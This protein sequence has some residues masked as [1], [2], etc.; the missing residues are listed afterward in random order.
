ML[1]FRQPNITSPQYL[2]AARRKTSSAAKKLL[3][4]HSM[5]I[6]KSRFE[7]A[8]AAMNATTPQIARSAVSKTLTSH[9]QGTPGYRATESWED[10]SK[11]DDN[12]DT[13]G[14][15]QELLKALQ[16]DIWGKSYATSGGRTSKNIKRQPEEKLTLISSAQVLQWFLCKTEYCEPKICNFW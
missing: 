5:R 15:R 6:W 7:Q 16:T 4:P 9:N 12:C 10:G 13:S 8:A 1:S 14:S 3:R 11:C 2:A